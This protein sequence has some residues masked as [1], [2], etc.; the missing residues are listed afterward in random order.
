VLP[1]KI[2]LELFVRR[3]SVNAVSIESGDHYEINGDVRIALA[4]AKGSAYSGMAALRTTSTRPLPRSCRSGAHIARTLIAYRKLSS[5]GLPISFG[6]C[7][8]SVERAG[9]RFSRT[10]GRKAK[11]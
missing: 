5:T 6:Q 9:P 1:G 4:Q 11:V 2:H 3:K 7:I 8:V 10:A